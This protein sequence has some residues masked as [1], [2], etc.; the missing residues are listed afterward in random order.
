MLSVTISGLTKYEMATDEHMLVMAH[1]SR[2]SRLNPVED[3]V[4]SHGGQTGDRK[5]DVIL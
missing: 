3:S 1:G 4:N 2:L 5:S